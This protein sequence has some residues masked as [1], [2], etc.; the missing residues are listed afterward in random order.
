M[1]RDIHPSFYKITF[2]GVWKPEK[3]RV[4][5]KG[6]F[7]K[8][9]YQVVQTRKPHMRFV[10]EALNGLRLMAS[11][12]HLEYKRPKIYNKDGKTIFTGIYHRDLR[13]GRPKDW[14][15]QVSSL[16]FTYLIERL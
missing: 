5:L 9:S 1:K 3:G 12:H 10:V 6:N 7:P 16:H 11:D 2:W 4:T 13:P 14:W 8:T 15:D